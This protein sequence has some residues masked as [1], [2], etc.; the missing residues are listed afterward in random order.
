MWQQLFG[1]VSRLISKLFS[2]QSSGD[3]LDTP[4]SAPD[5]SPEL[6]DNASWISPETFRKATGLSAVRAQDWYEHVKAACLAYEITTPARIAAFLAQVGH[7]SGSFVYTR[8]IWGPTAAQQR[9]EGRADLGNIYPG[10]GS[11]FRGRGLIQITGRF[12]YTQASQ[13]LGMDLLAHPELLEG[14]PLAALSAAW[15]WSANGCNAIADAGDLTR[16]TRVINGG[17]NGLEDRTRRWEVAKHA[18]GN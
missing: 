14:K 11:R 1:W 17:T 4:S 7:E 15:W 8:E 6:S 5:L 2:P 3:T 10:D 12:N 16:L 18:L 13:A 9:Y